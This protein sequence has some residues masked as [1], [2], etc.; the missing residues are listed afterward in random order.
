ML[1]KLKTTLK[2]FGYSKDH[3][4]QDTQVVVGLV[5]NKEGFPLYFNVFS[6]NTFEGE[7]SP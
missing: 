2:D 3:R 6:G 5:V 1:P 4:S 7:P